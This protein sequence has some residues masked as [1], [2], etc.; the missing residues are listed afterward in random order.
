MIK[1]KKAQKPLELTPDLEQLLTE[2]YKK[3]GNSVW[4]KSYIEKA[5]LISSYNKCCYCECLINEESKYME[6]DHFQDKHSNPDLV[7]TW[8]NLLP[9]CKRCNGHKKQ[10]DV[11]L[12]PIVN[13]SEM[14]PAEHF[15]MKSFRFNYKTPIGETTIKLLRLNDIKRLVNIRFQIGQ[16]VLEN[17]EN[18]LEMCVQYE[19]GISTSTI[20]RNRITSSTKNILLEATPQA[21]YSATVATEILNSV[22]FHN[23]VRILKEVSLWD[24]EM[25]SLYNEVSKL[26]YEY[27]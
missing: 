8:S 13:P 20:R 5:L 4:K 3:T 2:E 27:A 7:I 25:Q 15:T 26:A 17:V 6:I 1:I 23:V 18:L 10:H 12:E 22:H 11:I 24:S 14:V 16:C 21:E 9:S 19:K